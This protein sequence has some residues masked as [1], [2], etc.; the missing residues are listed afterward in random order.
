MKAI[1]NDA[2]FITAPHNTIQLYVKRC[3]CK[4]T[5]TQKILTNKILDGLEIGITPLHVIPLT[6]V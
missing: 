2:F 1:A 5:L 4:E 3:I 6:F